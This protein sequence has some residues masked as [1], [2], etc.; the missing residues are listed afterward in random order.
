VTSGLDIDYVSCGETT[1]KMEI[2][3][4]EADLSYYF[5]PEKVR[6]ARAALA[7]RSMDPADYPPPD[8]AIEIDTSRRKRTC[9]ADSVG[10]SAIHAAD[11]CLVT[12][13]PVIDAAGRPRSRV[14]RS[15]R[16]WVRSRLTSLKALHPAGGVVLIWAA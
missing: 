14:A 7:R 15:A 3:G 1:W 2:R 12:G 16:P 8:L 9:T 5:D 4:L 13:A 6:L 10:C 11:R